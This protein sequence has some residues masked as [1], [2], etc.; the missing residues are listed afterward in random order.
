MKPLQTPKRLLVA[1]S[2]LLQANLFIH[3]QPCTITTN[4]DTLLEC[5]SKDTLRTKVNPFHEVKNVLSKGTYING[6]INYLDTS[7]IYF[8]YGKNIY[9]SRDLAKTLEIKTFSNFKLYQ[10]FW[11]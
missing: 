3:S 7:F 2:L 6:D 11:L 1:I 5:G 8:A 10:N 9:I 4:K